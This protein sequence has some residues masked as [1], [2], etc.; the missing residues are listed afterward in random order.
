MIEKYKNKSLANKQKYPTST[1]Y[2][3]KALPLGLTLHL[4]VP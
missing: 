1:K 3:G 4:K 2:I